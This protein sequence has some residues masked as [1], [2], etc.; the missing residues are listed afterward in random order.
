MSLR[1]KTWLWCGCVVDSFD[2]I[3][4]GYIL[5]TLSKGEEI[6]NQMVF[7]L[8]S[9]LVFKFSNDSHESRLINGFCGVDMTT[10]SGTN[11]I[12][13]RERDA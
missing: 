3:R 11:A 9:I 6:K 2:N 5:S 12:M 1:E 7:Y 4:T 13:K 8:L 10:A